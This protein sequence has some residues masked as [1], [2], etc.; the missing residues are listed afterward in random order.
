MSTTQSPHQMLTLVLVIGS[1]ATKLKLKAKAVAIAAPHIAAHAI[2]G[3]GVKA[4]AGVAVAKSIQAVWTKKNSFIPTQNSIVNSFKMPP[5]PLRQIHAKK[6]AAISL[7]TAPLRVAAKTA[8]LKVGIAKAKVHVVGNV[9]HTLQK[10]PI[11]LPVPWPVPV[12]VPIAPVVVPIVKP[13]VPVA[14]APSIIGPIVK[15]LVPAVVPAVI[16]GKLG[17]VLNVLGGR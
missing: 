5:P 7:I 4:T 10:H 2:I 17:H 6:A 8:A 16:A 13:I 9:V 1:D 3:A 11:R 15:T 14:P 12:A